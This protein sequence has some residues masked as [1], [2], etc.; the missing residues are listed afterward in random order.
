MRD[1]Q[2]YYYFDGYKMGQEEKKT[3]EHQGHHCSGKCTKLPMQKMPYDHLLPKQEQ[4]KEKDCEHDWDKHPIIPLCKK[5][6]HPRF[7]QFKKEQDP[8]WLKVGD[9]I[10]KIGEKRTFKVLSEEDYKGTAGFKV[11]DNEDCEGW[12]PK[13][14]LNKNLFKKIKLVSPALLKIDSTR[15][16]LSTMLYSYA[17]EVV[18]EEMGG[19]FTSKNIMWPAKDQFGREIWYEVE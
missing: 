19:Y 6:G 3:K 11:L 10:R 7:A 14:Y 2:P 4:P 17:P 9:V 12:Y 18:E 15:R 1:D 13:K 5:C 16:R 8:F